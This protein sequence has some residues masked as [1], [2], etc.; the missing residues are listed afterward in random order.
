MPRI[1]TDLPSSGKPLELFIPTS[2]NSGFVNTTWTTIVEAPDFSV[3]ATGDDNVTE[4][5]DDLSRELRPGEVFF[6]TPLQVINNTAT[7]RWVEL[8]VLR[9]GASGQAIPAS[10]R[11]VVPAN[12]SVYLQIQGLRVL[13]TDLGGTIA[14]PVPGGRLQIQG[15]VNNA[16]T[17]LGAAVELEA[18]AHAPDSE[19][20]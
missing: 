12:D 2:S 15:E 19:A 1:R 8:R 6:E 16:L 5:P 13:K 3:P 4:D 20:P 11:V 10:P 9:Q 7:S 14:S 17:I 18:Q